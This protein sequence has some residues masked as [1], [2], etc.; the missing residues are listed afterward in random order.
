M[1]QES[2]EIYFLLLLLHSLVMNTVRVLKTEHFRCPRDLD[3][4]L[5]GD[6]A[7][8]NTAEGGVDTDDVVDVGVDVVKASAHQVLHLQEIVFPN[9][10]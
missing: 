6:E 7:V 8:A 5:P 2:F 4:L 9:P 1:L 10:P 3:D